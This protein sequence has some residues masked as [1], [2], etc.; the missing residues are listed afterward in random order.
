MFVWEDITFLSGSERSMNDHRAANGADGHVLKR[1]IKTNFSKSRHHGSRATDADAGT[2][3]QI[4]VSFLIT[5]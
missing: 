2:K 3:N 5:F 4:L 1:P